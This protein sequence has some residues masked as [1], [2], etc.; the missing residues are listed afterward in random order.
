MKTFIAI[1]LTVL[2]LA[3]DPDDS[4]GGSSSEPKKPDPVSTCSITQFEDKM[5]KTQAITAGKGQDIEKGRTLKFFYDCTIAPKD[6]KQT[7]KLEYDDKAIETSVKEITLPDQAKATGSF[8]VKGL[9]VGQTSIKIELG[10]STELVLTVIPLYIPKI[11]DFKITA[12]SPKAAGTN[13]PVSFEE[14][15][16]RELVVYNDQLYVFEGGKYFVSSDGSNWTQKTAPTVTHKSQEYTLDR[17]QSY[18]VFQDKL[19]A[20]GGLINL[21]SF[22][23]NTWKNHNKDDKAAPSSE[24]GMSVVW[25][26]KIWFITGGARTIYWS[27]DGL[28]WTASPVAWISTINLNSV[29]YQNQIFIAGGKSSSA[30]ESFDAVYSFDG[31]SL[32]KVATLPKKNMAFGLESFAGGLVVVGGGYFDDSGTGVTLNSL[33]YSPY[34]I[35][36]HV[37]ATDLTK[38]DTVDAPTGVIYSMVKWKPKTGSHANTEA[39]WISDNK[40]IYQIT[41]TGK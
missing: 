35:K 36:W 25:D 40:K 14:T 9:Q 30:Q 16:S 32:S 11:S 3:C 6:Y 12:I 1:M 26:N 4:S 23:G 38:G 28:D 10:T 33:W 41:Y 34:G 7:A 27:S 8:T 19:W 37:I 18:V 17:R 21:W 29:A 15:N 31:K 22:D 20:L 5:G 13:T 2:L 39:L 24:F